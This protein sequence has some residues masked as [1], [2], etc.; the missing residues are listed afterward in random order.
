MFLDALRIPYRYEVEGF[1]LDNGD[2]YLPDFWLPASRT[3]LEIKGQAPG[4]DELLKATKLAQQGRCG[5]V[6]A[7]CALAHEPT[8]DIIYLS[9]DRRGVFM[10]VRGSGWDAIM[11]CAPDYTTGYHVQ[12]ALARARGARFE[13]GEV[14][15]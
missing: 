9:H 10:S 3:W 11:S 15:Q 12:Q 5:V 13:F 4:E 8:L 7:W 6:I 2:R 1:D 14:G